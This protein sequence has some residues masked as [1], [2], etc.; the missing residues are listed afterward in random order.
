MPLRQ[1]FLSIS[2]R[3]KLG[4]RNEQ[5]KSLIVSVASD[6]HYQSILCLTADLSLN[7]LQFVEKK[8]IYLPKKHENI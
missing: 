2:K 4:V 8:L 6:S 5:T 3:R 7:H 1:S